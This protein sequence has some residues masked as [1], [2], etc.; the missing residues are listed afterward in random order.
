VVNPGSKEAAMKKKAMK[1]KA[2]KGKVRKV[3]DLA[4]RPGRTSS[5]KGGIGVDS[6][7]ATG[8][9]KPGEDTGVIAIILP[10]GGAR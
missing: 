1:K 4:A 10:Q 8:P 3:G 7:S 5:V 9:R 2:K 6:G